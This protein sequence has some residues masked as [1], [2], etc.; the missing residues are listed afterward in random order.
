MAR[1]SPNLFSQLHRGM[2]LELESPLATAIAR[3]EESARDHVVARL[4]SQFTQ[5]GRARV[6]IPLAEALVCA[7]VRV[8]FPDIA[9]RALVSLD[10][11]SGL[12]TVERRSSVRLDEPVRTCVKADASESGY[13]ILPA[14]N[15]S[16]RGVLIGW[17]G[18]PD[19]ALGEHV[20]VVLT[21][22]SVALPLRG[23]VVRVNGE[24]TAIKFEGVTDGC[25]DAI[26]A[27]IFRRDRRR[28]MVDDPFLDVE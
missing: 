4:E 7:T 19:L 11:F 3:I 6:R 13:R 21:L 14:L 8:S 5:S 23:E 20:E 27:Y 17:P 25:R 15:V 22:D 28:K 24:Q 26:V 18:E 1:Q 16:A 10:R 2:I 12:H 9:D